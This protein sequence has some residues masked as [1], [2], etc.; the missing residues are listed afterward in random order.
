ML[1]I[2]LSFL[3]LIS[4]KQ[5]FSQ[6][7]TMVF[8]EPVA[9]GMTRFFFDDNYFSV[10]KNCEFKAIERVTLFNKAKNQFEGEFKD[11]NL[12]GKLILTG[13][14]KEGKKEGTFKAYHPNGALRWETTYTDDEPLGT[15]KYY[16]PDGKPFLFITLS[17]S[18][19]SIDQQWDQTGKQTVVDGYGNYKIEVPIIGYTDHGY[20]T[21]IRSGKVFNGFPEGNWPIILIAGKRKYNLGYELYKNTVYTGRNID[22]EFINAHNTSIS[23]IEEFT[24]LPKDYFPKAEALYM[25]R[26]SFDEYTGFNAHLSRYLNLT[27]KKQQFLRQN[28][29]EGS[30]SYTVKVSKKGK[31]RVQEIVIPFQIPNKER[32]DIEAAIRSVNYYL[33]SY[34]ENEPIDDILTI[35][36]PFQV[37]D[38]K[39]AV[40]IADIQRQN[41]H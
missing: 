17:D 12:D 18:L 30:I 33:P 19:F 21:Y 27:L 8:F 9:N 28:I 3:L 38:T 40:Y 20:T 16:Y 10:E 6:E 34:H 39:V 23:S 31:S 4:V 13:T 22:W 24:I 26:C 5:S 1:R 11:F 14:Y 36:I 37:K 32:R 29:T 2:L 41:G 35:S 25:K 15:W 7:N